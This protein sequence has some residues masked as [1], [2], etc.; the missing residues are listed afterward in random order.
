MT[1]KKSIRLNS[2]LALCGAL[3]ASVALT[4]CGGGASQFAINT[5]GTPEVDVL[6]VEKGNSDLS[7]S[8]PATIKGKTDIEIRPQVS[9]FITQVHVQEG[10]HVT[11]GQPLFTLDQV[12]FKAAVEQAQAQAAAAQAQVNA[13][14]VGVR[15]AQLQLNNQKSLFDKGIIS[16]YTYTL[17]QNQLSTAQSQLSS[18]RSNLATAQAAVTSARKNLSYTVIT[19]P[20]SGVVGTIPNKEGS[21]ASP[22]MQVPLTTVSD[23]SDVYAYFSLNE[24]DILDLTDGGKRSLAAAIDALPAVQLRLS[25]GNIYGITGKVATVAGLIDQNTGAANVRARFANPSGMLVSGST[26][27][28]LIPQREENVILIPQKA[29]YEVQDKRFVYVLNDSN[30]TVPTAIE[31]QSLS[32]GKDYVVTSGLKPGQRIVVEGVGSTIKTAGMEVK[33]RKVTLQ[34]VDAKQAQTDAQ[35]AAQEGIKPAQ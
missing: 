34:Q 16:E 5:G 7:L 12:T 4:A 2:M 23:N 19:A 26:G 25:N 29:T 30:K 33:P 24:K 32:N 22:S 21:L 1:T 20:S 8:Y 15:N 11:K 17:A 6:T 28:I 9:G 18:A 31:V 10:Q 27:S 35:M 13:A 14:E 3:A